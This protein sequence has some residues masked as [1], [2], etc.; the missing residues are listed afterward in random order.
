M[1]NYKELLL[2]S[3]F[4]KGGFR[5]I[6]KPPNGRNLWQTLYYT[7]G[8]DMDGVKRH[9]AAS[10]SGG[11]SPALEILADIGIWLKGMKLPRVEKS[12]GLEETIM[13]GCHLQGQNLPYPPPFLKG[14]ERFRVASSP[15]LLKG[16]LGGFAVLAPKWRRARCPTAAPETRW[17]RGSGL[18]SSP[19]AA[20]GGG[21][22][23][24]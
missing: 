21:R 11:A 18:T 8:P 14:R 24:G 19:R 9:P 16:D 10:D 12:R 22:V 20:V 6:W 5:G 1:G 7:I 4:E 3:P 13:A 15:P 2:N 17:G 23:I